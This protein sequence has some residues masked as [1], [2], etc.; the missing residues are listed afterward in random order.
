MGAVKHKEKK[1][2]KIDFWCFKI[3]VTQAF[4]KYYKSE[5]FNPFTTPTIR[6]EGLKG[7]GGERLA[8]PEFQTLN[9]DRYDTRFKKLSESWVFWTHKMLGHK[10]L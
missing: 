4:Q 9:F 2:A 8:T 5:C 1:T 3:T 6:L 7:G 10:E